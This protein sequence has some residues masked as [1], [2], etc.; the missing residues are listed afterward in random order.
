MKDDSVSIF[1]QFQ[2]GLL[3]TTEQLVI[4]S[5]PNDPWLGDI[6]KAGNFLQAL[7]PRAFFVSIFLCTDFRLR[8]PEAVK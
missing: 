1:F 8:S 4:E 6:G 2:E 5:C 7:R 3:Q